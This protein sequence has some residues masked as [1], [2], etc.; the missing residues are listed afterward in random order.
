MRQHRR[1]ACPPSDR[2][3]KVVRPAPRVNLGLAPPRYVVPEPVAATVSVVG[4]ILINVD[5]AGK[6][7]G[8][9]IRER[10]DRVG[11]VFDRLARAFPRLPELHDPNFWTQLLAVG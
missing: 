4:Q 8:R 1:R 10:A 3:G 11:R 6:L 9:R 7:C 5:Q 2:R